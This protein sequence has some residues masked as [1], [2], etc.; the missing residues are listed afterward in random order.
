MA[1]VTKTVE[2][3]FGT[4]DNASAG[5][6]SMGS[7]LDTFAGKLG[8]VT[9]PVANF[10][11][12]IIK[13]ELAV[14]ALAAAYVGVALTNAAKFESA[15][16]DLAK[17]LDG[18]D[19]S[20]T[21]AMKQFGAEA[22]EMSET[23]GISSAD[24]VQGFAD[25]K[26]AGFEL[27]EVL[28]LQKNALDLVIAGDIEADQATRLLIS[29]LKGFG[30][31]ST[32][33]ARLIEAMNNVSNNFAT[34]LEEL[35]KGM[36]ILSPVAA[37][38]GLDF[39]ETAGLLTPIIEVFGSG[40]IAA[41]A[42]KVGLI[43]LLSD[44]KRVTDGLKDLEV[45]QHDQNGEL[46]IGE[47]ILKD[48]QMAFQGLTENQKLA[49]AA[50]LVGI[51]QAAKMVL[52]FDNLA[53][54]TEVTNVAMKETGSV[55]TEVQLRLASAELQVAKFKVAFTNLSIAIG[56]KLL[57]EFGGLTKGATE[58]E[59]AFR[60]VVTAGGLDG[61]LGPL[62]DQFDAIGQMLSEMAIALPKA[63]ELFLAGGGFDSIIKSIQGLGG[64]FQNLFDGVF[65]AGLD[66]T[67]PEDL[68]L[69]MEKLV[70]FFEKMVDVT[71]GI[72][73]GFKPLIDGIASLVNEFTEADGEAVK[74]GGQ[75]LGMVSAVDKLV[76]LLGFVATGLSTIGGVLLL[77]NTPKGIQSLSTLANTSFTLSSSIGKLLGTLGLAV[78]AFES[79]KFGVTANLEAYK[80]YQESI[81][82]TKDSELESI[83]A[84][85]KLAEILA[86]ISKETGVTI[87]SQEQLNSEI[88]K[89]N[90]V[91][92]S[93]TKKY[94]STSDAIK[95]LAVSLGLT[96][97]EILAMNKQVE[98]GK[99]IFD[100]ATQTYIVA[101]GELK[102]YDAI[103]AKAAGTSADA[104]DE[105][106]S[107]VDQ[108]KDLGFAVDPVTGALSKLADSTE[109]TATE[110]QKAL[111]A[112]K[113]YNVEIKNGIP[114]YTQLANTNEKVAETTEVVV[115]ALRN[116][117]I[118]IS[119]KVF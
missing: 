93:I 112:V 99:L 80:E 105:T 27:N 10:T 119:T 43:Q 51:N 81:E 36:S 62:G 82:R 25:F 104:V 109:K 11:S 98:E 37:Q 96:V 13:T 23:Y 77:L 50:Q 22:I 60:K 91:Q 73:S 101:T 32:E 47:D 113:G 74:F 20:V 94:S 61:L 95:K 111:V 71:A 107:Y 88:E 2:I 31:E 21:A 102:D 17:V 12:S 41:N 49:S 66:L 52:V 39:N 100:E 34:N 42:L 38:M 108:M 78:I 83:F 103:V 45:A 6:S 55:I 14:A 86:R 54:T 16:I 26:Q 115:D 57:A 33:A 29:S 30:I 85:E 110:Q 97:P 89:G 106:K 46:R 79:V 114:V 68:A 44:N 3:I 92:D 5:I 19:A 63:F 67:K 116:L 24:I 48:V 4:V 118:S 7:N 28:E 40:T 90:I 72:V 1:D 70:K 53:L 15:Q 18:D 9:G 59:I 65:G 117:F 56:D 64:E 75:L 69:V 76:P 35:A 87:T 58:L 8:S 84:K